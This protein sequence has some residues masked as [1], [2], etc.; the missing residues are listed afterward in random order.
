MLEVKI[1]SPEKTLYSGQAN[2]IIVPGERGL[3][4]V[5]T[6]HAPIVSILS[7]GE[8]KVDTLQGEPFTLAIEGGFIEVSLNNVTVCVEA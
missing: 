8:V 4:E 1:L 6:D 2:G 5:L 7:K 3:F